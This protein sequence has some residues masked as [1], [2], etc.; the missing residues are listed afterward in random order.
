MLALKA[1]EASICKPNDFKAVRALSGHEGPHAS[2]IASEYLEVIKRDS[3]RRYTLRIDETKELKAAYGTANAAWMEIVRARRKLEGRLASLQHP[4]LSNV[5]YAFAKP[6]GNALC[7]VYVARAHTM[8]ARTHH[9][10]LVCTL[11]H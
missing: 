4:L 5:A 6:S 2:V 3:G 11:S 7:V 9:C 8:P 10:T 1:K